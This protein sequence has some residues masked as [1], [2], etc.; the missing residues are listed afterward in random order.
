VQPAEN[1]AEEAMGERPG[2]VTM[3]GKPITLIGDELKAG[4][5]APEF[6][7][8]NN[9]LSPVAVSS[10]RGKVL[11]ISS[12]S[13]LDTQVCDRETQRFGDEA[14]NL[15]SDVRIVTISMDLPFAQKRAYRE[16]AETRWLE[17]LLLTPRELER[18]KKSL[19]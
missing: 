4:D 1:Q 2:I 19:N 14:G 7:A 13:S 17:Y 18:P 10:F 5:A 16:E 15:G 6:V 9:D 8:L 11:V 12:V 3:K